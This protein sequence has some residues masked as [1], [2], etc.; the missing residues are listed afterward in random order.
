MTLLVSKVAIH[1]NTYVLLSHAGGETP[2]HDCIALLHFHFA[3][4]LRKIAI[5]LIIRLVTALAFPFSLLQSIK[6]SALVA[7]YVSKSATRVFFLFVVVPLDCLLLWVH[8]RAL[9]VCRPY[10]FPPSAWT[11][12]DHLPSRLSRTFHCVRRGSAWN[13]RQTM[14]HKHTEEEEANPQILGAS[15]PL[16]VP[17]VQRKLL[18]Y[19]WRHSEHHRAEDEPAVLMRRNEQNTLLEPRAWCQNEILLPNINKSEGH[20]N[21]VDSRKKNTDRDFLLS[22]IF[23]IKFLLINLANKWKN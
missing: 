18:I 8:H 5:I 2:Q 9:W 10:C 23:T 17:M 1:H 14:T 22:D 21:N 7:N 6:D 4:L 15:Y 16:S 12:L 20:T 11:T 19:G 13:T 3:V